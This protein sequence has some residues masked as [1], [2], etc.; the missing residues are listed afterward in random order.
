MVLWGLP[1]V[2]ITA[3]LLG[4]II[5][6]LTAFFFLKRKLKARLPRC[7]FAIIVSVSYFLIYMNNLVNLD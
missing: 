1:F 7:I 4:I 6:F 3:A 2:V 5:Y